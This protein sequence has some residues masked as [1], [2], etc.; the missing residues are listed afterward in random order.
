M[1][2]SD[3]RD[4]RRHLPRAKAR[5]GRRGRKGGST[6]KT[7]KNRVPI[8]KRH[9]SIALRCTA[10]HWEADLMAF[11]RRGQNILVA[12]ERKTRIL[13]LAHQ[14]SKHAAPVVRRLGRWLS[15]LP[16]G[17]GKTM[18]FDNGTE[19]A[20]HHTLNAELRLKTY[21]CDP[22]SPWQKG[23]I[24]NAIGR[25]RRHLPRKTDLASLSSRSFDK[26]AAR[27]NNTPRKCL[28]WKTPAEP[29]SSPQTVALEM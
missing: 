14:P 15:S 8:G 22:H 25:M 2:R 9:P 21:L 6:L 19:F 12:H 13:L 3:D 5:R 28:G 11:S 26:A 27:Y 18:T 17:C 7:F 20:L 16:R 10:G 23:G 24:E 4:W 1:R 29:F